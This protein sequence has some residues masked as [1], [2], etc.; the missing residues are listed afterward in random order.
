MNCDL[1]CSVYVTGAEKQAK[2]TTILAL[3]TLMFIFQA[4][5]DGLV[6]K[7]FWSAINMEFSLVK[8]PLQTQKLN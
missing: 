8:I 5:E 3:A 4:G 7:H 1:L 2:V 6:V